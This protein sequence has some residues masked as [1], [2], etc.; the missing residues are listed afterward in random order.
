MVRRAAAQ[1]AG[2]SVAGRE[3]RRE[4]ALSR[5]IESMSKHIRGYIV[6][7]YISRRM[8]RRDRGRTKRYMDVQIQSLIEAWSEVPPGRHKL[9]MIRMTYTSADV[10]ESDRSRSCSQPPPCCRPSYCPLSRSMR[11]SASLAPFPTLSYRGHSLPETKWRTISV[12]AH[13]AVRAATSASAEYALLSTFIHVRRG[14]R[15]NR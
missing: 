11:D 4:G 5:F 13:C 10:A 9:G 15:L 14:T 3:F 8:T 6:S 7:R 1:D 12:C 2:D